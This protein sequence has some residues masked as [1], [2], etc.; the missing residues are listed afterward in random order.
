MKTAVVFYSLEGNTKFAAQTL[1]RR[2][3]GEA[4]ELYPRKAYPTGKVM[5]YLKGGSSAVKKE[6]PELKPYR[7]NKEE[8]DHIVLGSPLW[9][10]DISPVLRTF[11]LKNDLSGH[12]VSAFICRMGSDPKK[13]FESLRQLTHHPLELEMTLTSPK[14]KQQ[15]ALKQIGEFAAKLSS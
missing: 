1:A 5:K 4:V 7:F 2:L 11:L 12:K 14:S 8:Y 6:S 13:A 15:E 10:G 3:H 9:A